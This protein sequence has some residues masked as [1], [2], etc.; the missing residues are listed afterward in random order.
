LGRLEVGGKA[1]LDIWI[2]FMRVALQDMPEHALD[3]PEGITQAR[4]DPE[5]G[6][7]ARLENQAAIMEV[8]HM[9]SLPP[10]EDAVE[11]DHSDAATQEDPYDSF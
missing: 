10:M 4:I 2:D 3:I 5:T 6:L 9:G 8:F 11:G 1:A 7:L